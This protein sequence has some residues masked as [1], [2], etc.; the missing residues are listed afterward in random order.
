[1][2]IILSI[3][4][5]LLLVGCESGPPKNELAN[6]IIRSCPCPEA[7]TVTSLDIVSTTEQEILGTKVYR[8]IVNGELTYTSDC[9]SFFGFISSG[10]KETFKNKIVI[11]EKMNDNWVCPF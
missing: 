10:Q 3:L 8:S 9:R 7:A 4:V 2:R 1:M 5:I 11:M 6:C